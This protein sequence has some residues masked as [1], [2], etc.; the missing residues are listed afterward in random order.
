ML[1]FFAKTNKS[2]V[3]VDTI[4][5]DKNNH[6]V[7]RSATSKVANQGDNHLNFYTSI[8]SK[9]SQLKLIVRP[10]RKQDGEIIVHTIALDYL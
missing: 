5:Y 7:Q 1:S 9:A 8:P 6:I 4:F 3:I 2:I 10:W